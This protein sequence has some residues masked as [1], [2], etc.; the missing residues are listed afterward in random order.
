[1]EQQWLTQDVTCKRANAPVGCGHGSV[2]AGAALSGRAGR[3]AKKLGSGV[4]A[5]RRVVV[6][7]V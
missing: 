1:M 3:F 2:W 7:R 6:L 5:E 4:S